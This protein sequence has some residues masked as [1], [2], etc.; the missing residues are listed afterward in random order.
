MV[1]FWNNLI[2][3]KKTS[4][5]TLTFETSQS[6][7]P[8]FTT[9]GIIVAFNRYFKVTFRVS[10]DVLY[11]VPKLRSWIHRHGHKRFPPRWGNLNTP[12]TKRLKRKPSDAAVYWCVHLVDMGMVEILWSSKMIAFNTLFMM[13]TCFLRTKWMLSQPNSA[14]RN[15]WAS[16]M[17]LWWLMVWMVYV[18]L[19]YVTVKL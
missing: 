8:Y 17:A 4:H 6:V 14:A 5:R 3:L 19:S 10:S 1:K 13:M 16:N 12:L 15:L 7:H 9:P 18:C 2:Q 11:Y